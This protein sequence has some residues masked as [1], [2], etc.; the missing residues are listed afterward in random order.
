MQE[1]SWTA[2]RLLVLEML[3]FTAT[4]PYA[5]SAPPRGPLNADC[6]LAEPPAP[7]GAD[8]EFFKQ[9]G[10]KVASWELEKV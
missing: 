4:P 10:F 7:A 8:A 1:N 2:A 9:A 3:T 6:W 5:A